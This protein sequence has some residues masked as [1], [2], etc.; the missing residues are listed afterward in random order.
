MTRY[1]TDCEGPMG[2]EL[3]KECSNPWGLLVARLLGRQVVVASML[4][5][6]GLYRSILLH[7]DHC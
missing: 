1:W 5:D 4:G 3:L 6:S 7:D 2:Q